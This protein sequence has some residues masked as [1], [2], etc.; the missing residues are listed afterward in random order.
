[1]SLWCVC[2]LKCVYK[3]YE[4]QRI[5]KLCWVECHGNMSRLY[6]CIK[7]KREKTT[8]DIFIKKNVLFIYLEKKDDG[9]QTKV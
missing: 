8:N 5:N 1:M 7:S 3:L 9:P 4:N 2:K 6:F